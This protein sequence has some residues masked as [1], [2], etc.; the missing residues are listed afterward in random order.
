MDIQKTEKAAHD[1]NIQ[2]SSEGRRMGENGFQRIKDSYTN[3]FKDDEG[4]KVC[5][6][7]TRQVTFNEKRKEN[8]IQNSHSQGS[9]D[10]LQA[11]L[12][13]TT[14]AAEEESRQDT[15]NI[16]NVIFTNKSTSPLSSLEKNKQKTT[17]KQN[18][19]L[20]SLSR[21]AYSY[22]KCIQIRK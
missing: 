19:S 20:N 9:Y 22:H 8:S 3:V 21:K 7:R 14:P 18:I 1:R 15:N 16:E 5:Q 10:F 17:P 12:Q 2:F 13:A 4:D 6:N 11:F